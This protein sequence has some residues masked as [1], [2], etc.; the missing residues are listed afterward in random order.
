LV[1]VLNKN[2]LNKKGFRL[3]AAK[4]FFSNRVIHEWNTLSDEFIAGNSLN[5]SGFKRKLDRYLRDVQRIY[6]S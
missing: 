4:F 3:D 5:L 2:K 6:I 1:L